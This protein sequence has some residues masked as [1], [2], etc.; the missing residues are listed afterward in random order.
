LATILAADDRILDKRLSRV[1]YLDNYTGKLSI[2][3][4][5]SDQSILLVDTLVRSGWHLST[6]YEHVRAR[7][8]NI[9]G[10]LTLC[11]GVRDANEIS[12][13]PDIVTELLV[14]ERLVFMYSWRQL[15]AFAERK[16][17][18]CSESSD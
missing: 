14:R 5:D 12:T 3:R 16:D 6:G 1:H 8:G 7:G 10:V 17:F 9:A 2:D 4:F 15:L 13:M 18:H 11:L